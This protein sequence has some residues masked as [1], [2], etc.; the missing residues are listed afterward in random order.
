MT[1]PARKALEQE[2]RPRAE[3]RGRT[4]EAKP[5][6]H[7]ST[8]PVRPPRPDAPRAPRATGGESHDEP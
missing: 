7:R 1:D 4:A 6:E 8:P 2:L 5:S 3:K